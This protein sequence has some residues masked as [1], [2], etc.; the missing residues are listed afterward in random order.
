MATFVCSCCSIEKKTLP[1]RVPPANR[2]SGAN[3]FPVEEKSSRYRTS[4]QSQDPDVS[5]GGKDSRETACHFL[6][7]LYLGFEKMR[8]VFFSRPR[9]RR[10]R[11]TGVSVMKCP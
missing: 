7:S 6:S 10:V 3:M 11:W 4:H 1:R 2:H 5:F 8:K 9:G